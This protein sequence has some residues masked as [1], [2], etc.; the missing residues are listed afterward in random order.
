MDNIHPEFSTL[1]GTS[2][3]LPVYNF[4]NLEH[5]ARVDFETA[6]GARYNNYE[7]VFNKYQVKLTFDYTRP[8]FNYPEEEGFWKNVGKEENDG[9][10]HFLLFHAPALVDRGHIVFEPSI[11]RSV[12]LC[13]SVCPQKL[14]QWPYLLIGKS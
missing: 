11:C 12:P 9:N 13:L 14:L 1:T 3:I 5:S 10:Q 7:Y 4:Y 8:S 2:S 6:A